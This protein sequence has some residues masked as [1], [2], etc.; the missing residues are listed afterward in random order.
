MVVILDLIFCL[1]FDKF[2]FFI[3]L[4]Y[5]MYRIYSWILISISVLCILY[6]GDF[7]ENGLGE[8]FIKNKLLLLIW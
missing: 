6:Y 4:I 3:D 7:L 8:I 5:K 2:W 1:F